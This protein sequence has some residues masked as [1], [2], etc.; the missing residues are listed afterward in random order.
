VTGGKYGVIHNDH[1]V[2]NRDF[3]QVMLVGYTQTLFSIV[4]SRFR[5]FTISI[6]PTACKNGTDIFYN[7]RK[8]TMKNF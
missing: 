5:L 4:E 8:G 6:N 2:V 1:E 3:D 7:I